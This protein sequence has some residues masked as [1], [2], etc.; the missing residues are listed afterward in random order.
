MKIALII[1]FSCCFAV[2]VKA[3]NS[4]TINQPDS[5]GY[6][7][8]PALQVNPT[9]KGGDT[10]FAKFLKQ[11]IQYPKVAKDNNIS[12][13]VYISFII[14]KDGTLTN[15]KILRNPGCGMAEEALRVMKLSPAWIPGT[16]NGIPVRVGYTVPINFAL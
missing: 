8:I 2:V 16:Q 9:F 3:H 15:F 12:G 13:K 10:A 1:A 11:N 4:V 14:E 5:S 6:E 7:M